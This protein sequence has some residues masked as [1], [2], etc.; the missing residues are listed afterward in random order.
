MR[1]TITVADGVFSDLMRLTE[2][3]S[4]NEAINQALSEWVR[5]R[6]I[7]KLMNLRGKVSIADD[8]QERRQ[9]EVAEAESLDV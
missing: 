5:R 4:R 8:L 9:L 1:T 2:A 3:K 7:E 6:K